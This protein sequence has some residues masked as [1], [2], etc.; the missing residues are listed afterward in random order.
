MFSIKK[1]VF[2]KLSQAFMFTNLQNAKVRQFII[3]SFL[4]FTR[5]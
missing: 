2:L 5:N 3:A 4:V 1:H